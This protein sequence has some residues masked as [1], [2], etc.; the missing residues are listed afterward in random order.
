[1]NDYAL[2]ILRWLPADEGGRQ[3]PPSGLRYITLA[4]FQSAPDEEMSEPWSLIVEAPQPLDR[5]GTVTVTV[6][7]LAPEHAPLHYLTPG[8]HFQLLEGKRKVAAGEIVKH[9]R[10]ASN[11]TGAGHTDVLETIIHNK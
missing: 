7:F 10:S 9:G 4:R 2:A 8:T 11:R 6:R 3:R 5:A 1:M